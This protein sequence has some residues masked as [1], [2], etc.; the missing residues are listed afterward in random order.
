[1][2]V[3]LDWRAWLLNRDPDELRRGLLLSLTRERQLFG[4]GLILHGELTAERGGIIAA[5]TPRER[6][7][8][9]PD[10]LAPM[11]R[12]ITSLGGYAIIHLS[13]PTTLD[14]WPHDVPLPEL[15]FRMI[16]PSSRPV[17]SAQTMLGRISWLDLSRAPLTLLTTE[18]LPGWPP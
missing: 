5:V 7:Y 9:T 14:D 10:L 8:L 12:R 15:A 3:C 1:V 18:R 4:W 17:Y 16:P 11:R 13:L 2:I 6:V